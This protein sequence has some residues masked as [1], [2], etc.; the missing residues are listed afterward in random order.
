MSILPVG[1]GQ[2]WKRW[3]E[4]SLFVGQREQRNQMEL[5]KDTN[6]HHRPKRNLGWRMKDPPTNGVVK[7]QMADLLKGEAAVEWKKKKNQK[8][9]KLSNPTKKMEKKKAMAGAIPGPKAREKK[10]MAGAIPGPEKKNQKKKNAMA[11]AIP[12]PKAT[13][14]HL[15]NTLE[16]KI[17]RLQILLKSSFLLSTNE[18]IFRGSYENPSSKKAV[19]QQI[20]KPLKM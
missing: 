20:I 8:M 15:L 19:N 7:G 17:V 10:A 16:K 3:S 18:T 13:I 4:R 9:W 2:E 11:G 1:E 6:Q 14:E 5:K 12:G